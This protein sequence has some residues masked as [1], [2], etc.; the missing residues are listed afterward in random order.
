MLQ[1]QDWPIL[2]GK[3]TLKQAPTD[4]GLTA[5]DALDLYTPESSSCLHRLSR[6]SLTHFATT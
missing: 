6:N 4:L 5:K 3:K 1:G 2:G